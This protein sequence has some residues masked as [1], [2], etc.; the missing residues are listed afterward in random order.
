MIIQK[1]IDEFF[2]QFLKKEGLGVTN[3]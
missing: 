3:S 1:A 2:L